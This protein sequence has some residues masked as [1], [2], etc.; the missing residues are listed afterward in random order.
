MPFLQKYCI[1]HH[2]TFDVGDFAYRANAVVIH[3]KSSGILLFTDRVICGPT[4]EEFLRLY[5]DTGQHTEPAARDGYYAAWNRGNPFSVP[6]MWE[7]EAIPE[8]GYGEIPVL[9]GSVLTERD[10]TAEQTRPARLEP[11]TPPS[12]LGTTITTTSRVSRRHTL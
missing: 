2:L 4:I 12:E 10:V 7:D 3:Q 1:A 5:P 11:L 6:E 8:H 9:Q